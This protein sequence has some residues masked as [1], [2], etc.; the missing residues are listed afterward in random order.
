M[1]ISRC[2]LEFSTTILTSLFLHSKKTNATCAAARATPRTKKE[3]RYKIN[4]IRR[5]FYQEED[6]KKQN[7]VK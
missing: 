7:K 6:K 2:I 4:M 3:K 1:Q 5:K